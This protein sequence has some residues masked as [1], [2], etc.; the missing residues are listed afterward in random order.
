VVVVSL[1]IF[2]QDAQYMLSLLPAWL[3]IPLSYLG[4]AELPPLQSKET[5]SI[6]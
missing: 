3:E 2:E 1:C 4:H 6:L 5:N